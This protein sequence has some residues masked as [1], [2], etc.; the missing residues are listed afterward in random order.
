MTEN[1]EQHFRPFS[2]S[3]WM[4]GGVV[5]TALICGGIGAVGA[6][7]FADGFVKM[8]H[9]P[10]I[11][12]Q[13]I[14]SVTARMDALETRVAQV[15]A[16]QDVTELKQKVDALAA[17]PAPAPQM[18][19]A[20]I[21]GNQAGTILLALTQIKNAYEGD[22]SMA[23]G[24]ALLQQSVSDA[25]MQETLQ[26][27]ATL[28]TNQFP[29]KQRLLEQAQAALQTGAKTTVAA[30][31][32]TWKERLSALAGKFVSVEPTATVDQQNVGAQ[33]LQALS[34]DNLPVAQELIKALPATPAVA[35]LGAG[36]ETRIKARRLMNN[37]LNGA[38]KLLG[39]G[40]KGALY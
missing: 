27:L 10:A 16:P 11:P 28:A 12:A 31:P 3:R 1:N 25:Q 36:I 2:V 24:I 33:L 5:T 13:E 19:Q 17:A 30:V 32:T 9:D 22:Q 15:P 23:P 40:T 8:D 14:A 18:T 34:A 26:G 29:T 39:T 4:L 6:L 20:Q 21:T 7:F 37:L 38:T 35:S